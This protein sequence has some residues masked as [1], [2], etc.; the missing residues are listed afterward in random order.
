MHIFFV[1]F[2]V[3]SL[4]GFL[5]PPLPAKSSALG[6][7]AFS[8]ERVTLYTRSER[9]SHA[10]THLLGLLENVVMR[11]PQGGPKLIRIGL[12]QARTEVPLL[13]ENIPSLD[14][15]VCLCLGS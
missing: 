8:Y 1:S 5:P 3:R 4:G 13:Q 2:S 14:P 15:T 9:T 10:R 6:G 12:R 7:G 11:H